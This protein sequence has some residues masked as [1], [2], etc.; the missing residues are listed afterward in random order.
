MT[1][2]LQHLGLLSFLTHVRS[3]RNNSVNLEHIMRQ[4]EEEVWDPL[5]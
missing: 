3:T 4:K 2:I 5:N 1:I